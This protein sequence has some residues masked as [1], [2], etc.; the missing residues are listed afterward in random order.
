MRSAQCAVRSAQCVRA[1]VWSQTL[2]QLSTHSSHY[3][4]FRAQNIFSR[5]PPQNTSQL[6]GMV[7]NADK[8]TGGAALDLAGMRFNT[9][10]SYQK[11]GVHA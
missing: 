8:L 6:E 4:H 11:C 7:A 3:F 10:E 2:Q 1:Y 9:A 5:A